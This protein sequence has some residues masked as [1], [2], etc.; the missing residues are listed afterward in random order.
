MHCFWKAEP[1]Y[2]CVCSLPCPLC[3]SIHPPLSRPPPPASPATRPAFQPLTD[4]RIVH[5]ALNSYFDAYSAALGRYIPSRKLQVWLV[6][7]VCRL[8]WWA[9]SAWNGV[10]PSLAVQ[11][12]LD[13]VH[14]ALKHSLASSLSTCS[15]STPTCTMPR[16]VRLWAM[17]QTSWHSET[18]SRRQRRRGRSPAS[19][20]AATLPAPEATLVPSRRIDAPEPMSHSLPAASCCARPFCT[21]QFWAPHFSAI[22]SAVAAPSGLYQHPTGPLCTPMACPPSF[23]SACSASVCCIALHCMCTCD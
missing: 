10:R 11:R 1:G 21:P 20:P 4:C 12:I 3:I 13:I 17:M 18:R 7:L 14:F 5:R 22:F 2:A 16:T 19:R 8:A 15:T 23:I 9:S 6:W